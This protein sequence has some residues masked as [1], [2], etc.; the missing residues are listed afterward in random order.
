MNIKPGTL[1]GSALLMAIGVVATMLALGMFSA[2]P[3]AA[4][5]GAVIVMVT[6]DKARSIGQYTI[7]VSG[8]TGMAAIPV[9]G[10]IKWCLRLIWWVSVL[11]RHF[12]A[13]SRWDRI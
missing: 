11:M 9:G 12:V 4:D 7:T 13:S 5:I 10:S 6:P 1:F 2:K 3:A 8:A